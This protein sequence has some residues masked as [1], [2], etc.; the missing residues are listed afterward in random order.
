MASGHWQLLFYVYIPER[1]KKIETTWKSR[2]VHSLHLCSYDYLV[3]NIEIDFM[4]AIVFFRLLPPIYG[5]SLA[6]WTTNWVWSS[7]KMT[8]SESSPVTSIN[9]RLHIETIFILCMFTSVNSQLVY[10]CMYVS[11]C[12]C[13]YYVWLEEE[14]WRQR[15]MSETS[16]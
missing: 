10:V 2:L 11:V 6:C 5:R 9:A 3:P 15:I 1:R 4:L 12:V 16:R 7:E 8:M 14:T 13:V